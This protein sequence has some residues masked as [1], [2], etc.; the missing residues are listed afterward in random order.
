MTPS[1]HVEETISS[2]SNR[3]QRLS[4]EILPH[5]D[6]TCYRDIK[7]PY[8]TFSSIAAE[9][10]YRVQIRASRRGGA[11]SMAKQRRMRT[12]QMTRHNEVINKKRI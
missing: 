4:R 3:M 1:E 2:V 9:S 11:A 5:H 10:P 6:I 12:A 8:R 7:H